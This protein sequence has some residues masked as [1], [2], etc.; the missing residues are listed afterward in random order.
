MMKKGREVKYLILEAVILVCLFAAGI[1]IRI[2]YMPSESYG[3]GAFYD[4][5]SVG[6]Q[7]AVPYITGTGINQIYLYMLRGLFSIFGNV[8]QA[9]TIVQMVLF[10]LGAIVFYFAI[11][12]VNGRIGSLLIVGVMLCAPCFLPITYVYGPQMLFFLL[13]GVGLYYT[14]CFVKDC[15]DLE[16]FGILFIIQTIFTGLYAGLLI[17]LDLFSVI[18]VLPVIL[19]PYLMRNNLGVL[20]GVGVFFLWLVSAIAC[21]I[22]GGIVEGMLAGIPVGNVLERWLE[23]SYGQLFAFP[24]GYVSW[25]NL[26]SDRHIWLGLFMLAAYISVL[27]YFVIYLVFYRTSRSVRE[28]DV[29][30]LLIHETEAEE[31]A[32]AVI[33]Q[34]VKAESVTETEPVEKQIAEERLTELVNEPIKKPEE[35]IAFIENP[36]PLPKK[37]VKKNLDYA[38]QPDFEDM[39]YDI[40]VSDKDDYDLK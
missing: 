40:R 23:Y 39:D 6:N 10:I 26:L 11:R 20:K 5:A 9:G 35:S 1:G 14:H 29:E 38:F 24:Y 22:S 8:W 21:V 33:E 16:E 32:E 2:Y 4:A 7:N 19:L 36:L 15:A 34:N 3:L 25:E 18:L 30:G 13:F 27:V 28:L 17:Y 31:D 37:H 12:K